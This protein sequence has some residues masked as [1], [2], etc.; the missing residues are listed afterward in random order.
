M[1]IKAGLLSGAVLT[2]LLGGCAVGPDY[3]PPV[4][5]VAA[6]YTREPVNLGDGVLTTTDSKVQRDWWKAYGAPEI[7][8]LVQLAL[9]NNPSVEV[10]LANLKVAKEN[11][12]AQRGYYLPSVQLGVSATQQNVGS[13][14]SSPLSSGDSVY[15]YR[16]A[17][18]S[19]GFVPDIFGSNRRQVESLQAGADGQWYQ[20]QATRVT[21]ASN[22]VAA[23]IQEAVLAEQVSVL[24]AAIAVA[25]EQLQHTRNMQEHGY[26][27]GI[28]LAQ[29]ENSLTQLQLA[30]PPLQKQMQQTRDFLA[31]LCGRGP[32]AKLPSVKLAQLTLPAQLP[33]AIPSQLVSQRPD[34]QA[35]LSQVQASSAQIGVAQANR[36]PQFLITALAGGGATDF[37]SMFAP[38]NQIWAL[39]VN[40]TQPLF[41]GGTLTAR[42]RAAEAA[43][44]G[45]VAQYRNV[46]LTAFQNVADSLYALDTDNRALLMAKAAETANQKSWELTQ[47]QLV[48]GYASRPSMLA[49]QQAYLLGKVARLTSLGNY[50]SDTVAL[51]LALGGGVDLE[52]R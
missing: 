11:V 7:D 25:A 27:S 12:A 10:A 33:S 49:T 26:A 15:S 5:P 4:A 3:Q 24:Q 45:A 47:A 20:L 16:S 41:S 32:D 44:T 36:L 23:A 13:T 19:V 31:L 40:L 14:Q 30:L 2:L 38:G 52:R 50:L 6:N 35:A 46:V 43:Y 51:Q 8:Q 48:R 42:K 1:T 22:V 21:L 29:Q 37:A 39:G 28:D 18:L 9:Q 17:Q 34:I